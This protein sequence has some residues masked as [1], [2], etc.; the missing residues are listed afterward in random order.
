MAVWGALRGFFRVSIFYI[1]LSFL[2]QKC[3]LLCLSTSSNPFSLFLQQS[4]CLH[5]APLVLTESTGEN[6][7]M[8]LLIRR[9]WSSSIHIS[10]IEPLPHT[11]NTTMIDMADILLILTILASIYFLVS[12][13]G[14]D[15]RITFCCVCIMMSTI[16]F[17]FCILLVRFRVILNELELPDYDTRKFFILFLWSFFVRGLYEL[18]GWLY[19]NEN[20]QRWRF[21][22]LWRGASLPLIDLPKLDGPIRVWR[23]YDLD[24]LKNGEERSYI[25]VPPCVVSMLN[26]Y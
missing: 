25:C 2:S 5:P 24:I 26:Q 21:W 10:H 11:Q 23:F 15:D 19:Q 9:N 20:V 17:N 14:V 22:V 4:Y 8:L 18:C 3:H 13:P 7:M 1:L 6:Y 16:L 12:E